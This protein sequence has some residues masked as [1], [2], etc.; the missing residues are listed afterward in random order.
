MLWNK[1]KRKR[2]ILYQLHSFWLFIILSIVLGMLSGALFCRM[3]SS[4]FDAA[5]LRLS[6]AAEENDSFLSAFALCARFPALLY[7]F[8]F[9]AFSTPLILVTLFFRGFLISYSVLWYMFA[10]GFSGLFY[11][12]QLNLFHGLLLLPVIAILGGWGIVRKERTLNRQAS[13]VL[14]FSILAVF[15]VSVPEFWITPRVLNLLNSFLG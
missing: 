10:F 5:V 7:L 15:A 2:K 1:V 14:L 9:S 4:S 13:T 11:G 12:I 6:P 3:G 8:S